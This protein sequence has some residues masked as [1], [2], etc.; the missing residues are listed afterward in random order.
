MRI[1]NHIVVDRDQPV[2]R[3]DKIRAVA[4]LATGA[5]DEGNGQADPVDGADD[6]F[7]IGVEQRR[8]GAKIPVMIAHEAPPFGKECFPITWDVR[9]QHARG[10]ETA[11]VRKR[12]LARGSC[13]HH[14]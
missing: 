3:D 11:E 13:M 5:L 1:L 6:G 8:V 12:A 4:A 9:D 2:G 7:R 14:P 10:N